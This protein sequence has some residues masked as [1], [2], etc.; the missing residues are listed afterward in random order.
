MSICLCRARMSASAF[1]TL[2]RLWAEA[3]HGWRFTPTRKHSTRRSPRNPY[4][5]SRTW[6]NARRQSRTVHPT[7]AAFTASSSTSRTVTNTRTTVWQ[8][9]TNTIGTAGY[10]NSSRKNPTFHAL[11]FVSPDRIE[12]STLFFR[13]RCGH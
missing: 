10:M 8:P 11:A 3:L 2:C 6:R 1:S 12:C 13:V 7:R 9:N 4:W 5:P